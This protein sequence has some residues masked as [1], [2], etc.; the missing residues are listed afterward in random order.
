MSNKYLATGFALLICAISDLAMAQKLYKIVD[1]NGNVTFSQFPPSTTAQNDQNLTVEKKDLSNEAETSIISRGVYQYCG[2]IQLPNQLEQK[3][4]FLASLSNSEANWQRQLEYKQKELDRLQKNYT[5]N[6]Y[7]QNNY[8]ANHLNR[9]GEL[10]QQMRDLRC[11][12]GWAKKQKEQASPEIE[13]INVEISRL[14][15]SLAKLEQTQQEKCGPE[16][17]YEP[18]DPANKAQIKQWKSCTKDYRSDI[19]KLE[20]LLRD[21]S[22]KIK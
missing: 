5:Q 6:R 10:G 4:Y 15:A 1:A 3:S 17:I 12:L 20:R 13:K 16:P 7:Y 14:Q 19:N 22:R 8:T 9:N 11:A 18:N 21:E 2:E